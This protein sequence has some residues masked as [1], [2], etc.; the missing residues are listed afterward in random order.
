[1]INFE[2]LSKISYGIYIISSGDRTKGNGFVANT[3]LQ[4]TSEPVKIAICSNKNNFTTELIKK[5]EAFSISILSQETAPETFG[6]FGYKS[7]IDF[8]KM[9]GS[10]IKYG[11]TGVPIV[12]DDAIAYLECKLLQTI[13][14]GSHLLFIGELI[15]SDIIETTK[16]PITYAYYRE[17]K[18]GHSPKNAPTYQ[19]PEIKEIANIE[20]IK[21][22]GDIKKYKCVVCS[23]VYDEATENPK[24]IDLPYYWVCPLC[25]SEKHVFSEIP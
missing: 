25:N 7:G 1:M 4:V 21:N 2:A 3:A 14:V 17:V 18:K 8:D 19:K 20:E 13:D 9:V 5:H 22:N 15:N 24:F 16:K 6:K 10:K 12:L 23:Y 11:S